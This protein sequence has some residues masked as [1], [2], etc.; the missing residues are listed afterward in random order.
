M[1]KVSL[2]RLNHKE[3]MEL[4]R[5]VAAAIIRRRGEEMADLRKKMAEMA[6]QS[7][8]GLDELMGGKRGGKRGAVAIKYRNP[9]DHS[10]TWTGRGRKPNW[11]VEAVKKGQKL[12]SF[13][14]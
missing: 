13:A 8:F 6:G 12:E 10:Q 3:L 2:D 9:K 14:I 11:I 4:Q 1:A 5:E 7:G